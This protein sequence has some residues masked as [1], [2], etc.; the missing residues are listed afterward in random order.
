MEGWQPKVKKKKEYH[1][2]KLV[3]LN[4]EEMFKNTIVFSIKNNYGRTSFLAGITG[5]RTIYRRRTDVEPELGA[6]QIKPKR[7]KLV[8]DVSGSMYR[9]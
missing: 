1:L 9:Y 3:Q 6:P 8:V 4:L 2:F 5:E 7:L